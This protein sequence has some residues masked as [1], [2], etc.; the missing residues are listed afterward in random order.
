MQSKEP[1][2]KRDYLSLRVDPKLKERL[3]EEAKRHDR[4]IAWLIKSYIARCMP[5]QQ[6]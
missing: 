1:P 6:N 4:S 3:A 5:P 2:K